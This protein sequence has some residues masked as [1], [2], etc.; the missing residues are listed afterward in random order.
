MHANQAH[1]HY[2]PSWM[3]GLM[4]PVFLRHAVHDAEGECH[5]D[6]TASP[7][8]WATWQAALHRVAALFRRQ[9]SSR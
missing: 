1:P 4:D 3:G 6:T 2:S 7:S 9:S 8:T 5:A